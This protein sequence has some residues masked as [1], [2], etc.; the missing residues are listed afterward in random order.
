[1]T[2]SNP[3]LMAALSYAAGGIPV[4][5]C[6][7][8]NKRPLT[9][10]ESA[11]GAK[12]GGLYLASTDEAQ[13]R[14]WWRRF[15]KALIGA[16]T[17]PVSGRFVVDL[18][19]RDDAA[20]DML[21]ALAE[22]CGGALTEPD[23][24]TGEII[25]P[26]IVRT[27]SGGFHLWYAYSGLL[28]GER[29]GNRANLFSKVPDAPGPIRQ[30]VDVRGDGGYVILPPSQMENGNVYAWERE[31]SGFQQAPA[32]LLDLILRRGEFDPAAA[33]PSP[34]PSTG[35]A[36]MP[37][38]ED[39][40][41][42]ARRKYALSALERETR[43]VSGCA[44]GG[45]NDKLN[46]AAF[47]LGTLV[48]AG[49]LSESMAQS[50]LEDAA[51]RCGL[52]RADGLK[53]VRDTIRSGLEGGKRQPRDLSAIER[54]AK[55]RAERRSRRGSAPRQAARLGPPDSENPP[56]APAAR[57]PSQGVPLSPAGSGELAK[58]GEMARPE[59]QGGRGGRDLD[60]EL[61]FLPLTD[62]GNAARFLRRFGDRFVHC[63]DWGWLMWDGRR[64]NRE[65]ATGRV[66]DAVKEAIRLIIGEAEALRASGV[67][68]AAEYKR[69]EPV[70]LSDKVEAWALTS[71][72]AGHVK[73]IESLIRSDLEKPV[74]AFDADK[75][76]INVANGTLFIRRNHNGGLP[77]EGDY[78][79]FKP[80]DRA[81]LIT[82][83]APVD[84]DPKAQAPFYDDFLAFVQPDPGIRRF[85]H[86]WGGLS[87]T[88]DVSEQKLSFFY[89]K[90]KNGKSTLVDAWAHVAG[91]YGETVPIET[92]LDQGR[93][94]NAGAATPD[95]AILP[96]V[97]F[98]R[99]SE[100]EKGAKLA[101]ALI[102][103][104]TG[105]EAIQARH[106][107]KDYFKF[108]P[109]FKL[110]I[111]GNYRPKI[112]G[113]DDGIWRRM[114]LIPWGVTVPEERRDKHLID[115]LKREGSGILNRILDG[116]REWIDTGLMVPEKVVEAT[117]I[118]RSDSDPLGRFLDICTV[119]IAGQR[120]QS[121]ELYRL[122]CAWAKVN[123]EREWSS[124]GFGRALRDRGMTSKQSNVIWW[125]DL[126]LIKSVSDFVDWEGNPIRS[127]GDDD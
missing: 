12:D 64:W 53:S 11:P 67:D 59:A 69:G 110:T 103:L 78:I 37:P 18:D 84:Y 114:M 96:G 25:E 5:P 88:G 125:L 38:T 7:P 62:L 40:V 43:D 1:M 81:D 124:T 34:A 75:E 127:S 112:D 87:F 19:P 83:L 17:G 56:P 57:V 4:F 27:Q 79:G 98:L 45:R 49:V 68:E 113:T 50:G 97:R 35:G 2:A 21:A 28:E 85:L 32:R 94:R 92:F 22:W 6:S 82:K 65:G 16:R 30:H 123:G 63:P 29:L 126:K 24:K 51:V 47:A 54:E 115:K 117:E 52:V 60:V 9:P 8:V 13:I 77:T 90:G 80:H 91:D 46:R 14:E 20:G 107:N 120:V 76:K 71:Q 109:Q 3:F 105:G 95:L 23:G 72:A 116:L 122:F 31:G 36:S 101:E 33:L 108:Y 118:Y 66:D 41:E 106:L 39:V 61:A 15:P 48:G 86:Q 99:T 73:C 10:A 93:G 119:S 44:E 74:S 26:P 70:M 100:P 111:S 102:K 58:T 89:G 104:A 121:S 55:E 42:E